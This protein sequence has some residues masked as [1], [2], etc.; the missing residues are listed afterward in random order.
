M[1]IA[2]MKT[3]SGRFDT[4][5]FLLYN[6]HYHCAAA[7]AAEKWEACQMNLSKRNI[8]IILA[9]F[10]II[11]GSV[12]GVA[13]DIS[14]LDEAVSDTA[15]YIIK[16]VAS[17]QVG[18]IGGE[19]AVLGLAR[20]EL[21]LPEA[22]FK[23]YA[24]AA[25]AYVLSCG[26]VLHE[27]KYTEYSRVIAALTAIGKD[28]RNVA[29]YNLLTPLGNFEK[30]VW[31]G[32]NGA[33]WALIALDCGGYDIP[34]INDGQ[35]QAT[36]EMYVDHI[37]ANQTEDGGWSLSGGTADPEMT[38]MALQALARYR[39]RE[40]VKNAVDR[41]LS[42]LSE[43]QD[44]NAGFKSWGEDNLESSVQVLVGLCE[45]G[46]SYD[47]PRFVKNGKTL[48]DNLLSYYKK[49][50][51]FLHAKDGSGSEL[52]AT[53]QGFYGLV[54]VKRLV[55]GKNSL[56][57]MDD[58]PVIS[59]ENGNGTAEKGLPGKSQDIHVPNIKTPGKTFQDI[60]EHENRAAI[61][62]LA[63]RGIITGKSEDLFFPDA[64]MTRAEFAAIVVRSLGLAASG[65][66]AFSDVTLGDWFYGAVG[67]AHS[68]GI[69]NGISE[70][71]FAPNGTITREAAAVMTERCAALCGMDTQI[72][73]I[74]VRDVLAGFTDYVK[75][76]QWAMPSLAICV[77]EG[78]LSDREL[79]LRPKEPVT[80]AEVAQML[81]N[82]L[83]YAKLL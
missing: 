81:F 40:D 60:G 76:S 38:G 28:P 30:T 49:G 64:T 79:E 53:E 4:A 68:Y 21:D 70:T 27:K 74:A 83:S 18:S 31:Q 26:G 78:I 1:K 36:R 82:L 66:S 77:R 25:E 80:R 19:W 48:L 54:A 71:E 72:D 3:V 51:G 32:I 2:V 75:S 16:T 42:C 5:L 61:E 43:L 17:P 69:V 52:M 22:Y 23:S 37:L 14:L 65:D 56:Y 6:K 9:F 67:A 11:S 59:W 45:L 47:D 46:I 62:A 8:G 57:Q 55:E 73:S 39:N 41:A 15:A 63:A 33:I 50:Q 34:D 29:G 20:S 35:T 7:N 10:M 58:R 13:S 24:A 44:E 12:R